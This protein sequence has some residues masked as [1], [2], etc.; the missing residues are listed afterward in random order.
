VGLAERGTA[1]PAAA[2]EQKV[3]RD[4]YGIALLLVLGSVL[5]LIASGTALR[6]VFT[7]ASSLCL[8]AALLITLRVSGVDR[9]RT[10]LGEALAVIVFGVGAAALAFVD[11]IGQVAALVAWALLTMGTIA[12][13]GRRLRTYERVTLQ[14]VMGLLVVYLLLGILF[15]IAYEMV[16]AVNPPAFAQGE[17]GFS[18]ALYYSFITMATVG[19][20]DVSPGNDP[21]RALAVA[22]SIIGQLYLVSVVSLAVSRLGVRKLPSQE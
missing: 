3:V 19:Y 11:G 17:Q 20:G 22:E 6:S 18:G 9:T 1:E 21:V 2:S 10:R 4:A 7:F 12:A 13:V 14:L 15:G 8:M 16:E 5:G